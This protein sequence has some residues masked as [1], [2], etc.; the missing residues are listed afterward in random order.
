MLME[1]KDEGLENSSSFGSPTSVS[2][3]A[4]TCVEPRHRFGSVAASELGRSG[5]SQKTQ[6]AVLAA[7]GPGRGGTTPCVSTHRKTTSAKTEIS[8]AHRAQWTA[9]HP[10]KLLPDFVSMGMRTLKHH[11][12]AEKHTAISSLL[13]IS[14][15]HQVSSKPLPDTPFPKETAVSSRDVNTP[16]PLALLECKD[17]IVLFTLQPFPKKVLQEILVMVPSPFHIFRSDT[18]SFTLRLF[19]VKVKTLAF[20]WV[21]SASSFP[22][23]PGGDFAAIVTPQG[24]SGPWEIPA[25][26]SVGSDIEVPR[27]NILLSNTWVIIINHFTFLGQNKWENSCENSWKIPADAFVGSNIKAP[28]FN[29]LL[30]S[31]WVIIINNFTF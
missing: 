20:L 12:L 26:T 4:V 27:F 25:G 8:Y 1:Q 9:C 21:S 17:E 22:W 18:S 30:P 13:P 6:F 7:T 11:Y 14:T 29:K 5:V 16:L 24:T 19:T 3:R 23:D 28:Q 15:P 10:L 2:W 31:N